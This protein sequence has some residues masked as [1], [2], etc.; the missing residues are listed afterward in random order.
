[1]DSVRSPG[2]QLKALEEI[3][4]R[5]F[6][7]HIFELKVRRISRKRVQKD[8]EDLPAEIFGRGHL[9]RKQGV[10]VEIG[11]IETIEHL[12]LYHCIEIDEVDDHAGFG[13]YRAAD[14]YRSEEH[15]SE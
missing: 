1:L 15:T 12:C 14:H 11:Q 3:V 7:A 2:L 5:F 4:F 9:G 8:A 6:D 13:G 10:E